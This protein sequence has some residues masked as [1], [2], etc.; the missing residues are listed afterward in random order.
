M[1]QLVLALSSTILAAFGGTAFA[2]VTGSAK[3]E[4]AAPKAADINMTQDPK[5]KELNKGGGKSDDYSVA[6]G[7]LADGLGPAGGAQAGSAGLQRGLAIR[8]AGLR[9]E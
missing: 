7:K 8:R 1:R 9:L 3:L 4:G 6:G 5:C 2:D